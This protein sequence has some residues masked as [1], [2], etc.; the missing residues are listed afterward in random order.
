MRNKLEQALLKKL[1]EAEVDKAPEVAAAEA[2]IVFDLIMM[3][4]QNALKEKQ[5]ASLTAEIIKR[6]GMGKKILRF[7][8]LEE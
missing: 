7:L 5:R 8:G 4:M 2:Q 3:D 6:G 1:N